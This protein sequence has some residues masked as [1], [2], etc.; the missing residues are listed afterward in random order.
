MPQGCDL[1]GKNSALYDYSL[2]FFSAN[3]FLRGI[4][5]VWIKLRIPGEFVWYAKWKKNVSK[6]STIIVFASGLTNNIWKYIFRKNPN[7]RLIFWFWN[8]VNAETNPSRLPVNVEKWTFNP[9]DAAQYGMKSNIQFYESI[10]LTKGGGMQSDVFFIGHDKGRKQAILEIKGRLEKLGLLCNFIILSNKD[11]TI[12]YSVAVQNILASRAVLEINQNGQDGLTLR[13]LEALFYGKKLITNN[14]SIKKTP[15]FNRNNVFVL[16]EDENF[17][18]FWAHPYDHSV[19]N[20]KKSY[21]V[22][23]WLSNFFKA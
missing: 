22:E 20:L 13:A 5:R 15:L 8:P 14:G 19:D 1:F 12:P 18:V 6:Y 23:T 11:K 10:N 4:R 16:G 7:T 3:I 2:P 17:E 21:S 9:L